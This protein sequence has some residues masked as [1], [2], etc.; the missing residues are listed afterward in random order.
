MNKGPEDEIR[1]RIAKMGVGEA[2]TLGPQITGTDW[3]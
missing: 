1:K 3:T 2:V